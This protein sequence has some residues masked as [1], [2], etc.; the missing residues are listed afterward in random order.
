M[1]M[2]VDAAVSQENLNIID[3][4]DNQVKDREEVILSE[5]RLLMRQDAE[6]VE[7]KAQLAASEKR[8]RAKFA[9]LLK[10]S[11]DQIALVVS[12]DNFWRNKYL[13]SYRSAWISVQ[14]AWSTAQVGHDEIE[15][16]TAKGYNKLSKI[17]YDNFC[18]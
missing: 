12:K 8:G 1:S 10:Y 3:K 11:T 13:E 15:G 4:L 14:D 5:K 7:L 16:R 6:I 9:G 18:I 17:D 2:R